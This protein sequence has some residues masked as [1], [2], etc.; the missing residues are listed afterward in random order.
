MPDR[1]LNG[2]GKGG[3]V[4]GA[5]TLIQHVLKSLHKVDQAKIQDPVEAVRRNAK[6]AALNPEYVDHAYKLT[7][8][9]KILDYV[10]EVHD[11]QKLISQ[12]KK[13]PKCGLKLCHC[14]KTILLQ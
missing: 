3:K 13:C 11:E 12:H 8:P 10:S 7:E 2:P 9:V 14:N 6:K 5:T 4:A 1:P